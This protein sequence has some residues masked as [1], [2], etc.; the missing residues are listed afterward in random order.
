MDTYNFWVWRQKLLGVL[1]LLAREA[2]ADFSRRDYDA[3]LYG[4]SIIVEG[5]EPFVY[6]LIGEETIV[7]SLA[8]NEE[9]RDII[10]FNISGSNAFLQKVELIDRFQ[11]SFQSWTI[12]DEDYYTK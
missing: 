1:Y 2:G 12:Q 7:I 6:T 3:V 5:E 8:P 10:V 9:D 11:A 4:L